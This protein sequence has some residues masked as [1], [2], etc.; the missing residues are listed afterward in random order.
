MVA[1]EDIAALNS[2]GLSRKIVRIHWIRA[3]IFVSP[4]CMETS[5]AAYG[6]HCSMSLQQR[7]HS[8]TTVSTSAKRRRP[9]C[10]H[11]CAYV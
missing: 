1:S 9:E 3:A 6:D 2:R 10:P 11:A 8:R 7:P 5:K 4:K